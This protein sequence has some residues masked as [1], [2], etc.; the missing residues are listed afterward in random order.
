MAQ[1]VLKAM[2]LGKLKGMR[3]ALLTM[4][5]MGTGLVW[6]ASRGSA[7]GQESGNPRSA[8]GVRAP[9]SKDE[10][11]I[12]GVWKLVNLEQV[13]HQPTEEEKD[14]W[15]A[16]AVTITIRGNKLTFDADKS[17]MYFRLDPSQSPNLITL[18]V[19]DGPNKGR[20][21]PAIY[22][23]DCDD[24]MIC[25]GRLGD[26]QPPAGF[27]VTDRRPG[28]FPTLW[29][30]KRRPSLS[31][32]FRATVYEVVKDADVL[33]TR[34]EVESLP[35][36][37]VEV[38]ADKPGRGG[39]LVVAPGEP[40]KPAHTQLTILA[41][42]VEWKAGPTNVLKFMMGIKAGAASSTMSDTG[43]MPEAKRLADVLTM[44]LQPGEYKYG[45]ATKLVTYKDVTY[46]LV[47]KRPG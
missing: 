47:V 8:T 39:V 3:I 29:T 25:Q 17:F 23:L 27:S 1:R 40:D 11:A 14:A 21:V 16:G 24:L 31:E 30:F 13:S 42:H 5:L 19:P 26:T 36:A 41:D 45:V 32:S 44:A 35:G 20:P 12:Q 18:E 6:I 34:I 37:T 46:S 28:T 15:R 7:A 2:L 38:V 10:E 4:A 22:R 9:A 43:P 33:V